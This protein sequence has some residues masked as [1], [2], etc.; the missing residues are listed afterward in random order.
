MKIENKILDLGFEK[1]VSNKDFK[2]YKK[3]FKGQYNYT[4]VITVHKGKKPTLDF[5]FHHQN[6]SG[7]Y[8]KNNVT[9]TKIKSIIKA[10]F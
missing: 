10:L 1:T 7:C 5:L 4:C 3:S 8:L 9:I 6:S 2:S